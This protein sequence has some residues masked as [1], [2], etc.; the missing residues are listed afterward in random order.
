M[1]ELMVRMIGCVLDFAGRHSHIYTT[2]SQLCLG[3]LVTKF[4]RGSLLA[5]AVLPVLPRSTRNGI[6]NRMAH[7][8]LNGIVA[9]DLLGHRWAQ[10]YPASRHVRLIVAYRSIFNFFDPAANE[11]DDAERQMVPSGDVRA[12][13][14]IGP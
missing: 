9:S 13:N 10:H 8:R 4:N 1:S 7:H 5:V 14:K 6:V 2:Q 11:V 12:S 3:G